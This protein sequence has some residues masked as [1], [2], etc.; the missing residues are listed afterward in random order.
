M[1]HPTIFN[2]ISEVFKK[3]KVSCV[4]IGG[5]A[6]NYYKYARQTRD[7]DFLVAEEDFK[8]ILPLFE[9]EG[10]K[11]ERREKLFAR[12]KDS[13]KYR[14]PLNFMFVDKKTRDKIIKDGKKM[15][16]IG[17]EFIV[18]ALSMD[19][20]LKFVMFNLKYLPPAKLSKKREMLLR[21]KVPFV[22]K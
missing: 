7:I 5:F 3:A 10:Y 13:G 1:R 20:Y 14:V 21:V 8:K 11:E 19:D 6:V 16:F 9:K 15:K 22:I 4:L 2:L 18:S 17:Q 12:L